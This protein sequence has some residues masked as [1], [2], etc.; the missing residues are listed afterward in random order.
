MSNEVE[1][2]PARA[3][4]EIGPSALVP[5]VE[6]HPPWARHEFTPDEIEIIKATVA[7]D[8]SDIELRLFLVVARAR[9]LD[10]FARQIYA[11]QRWDAALGRKAMTIQTSIDGLRL[12]A[13]RTGEYVGQVGPEWCG[14]DGVWRDAWLAEDT[15]PAAARVGVLR[16]GWEA[17]LWGVA[18]WESYV[19]RRQD[20]S[21]SAMWSRMSDVM[22]AKAAEAL[23]LRRTFPQDLSG[24]YT[25]DEMAQAENSAVEPRPR[26]PAPSRSRTSTAREEQSAP[27]TEGA[28]PLDPG[29]LGDLHFDDR[30]EVARVA[31][32]LLGLNSRDVE[33][34]LEVPLARWEGTPTEA[35]Q[36]IR[37]A[38]GFDAAPKGEPAGGPQVDPDLDDPD[39][40]R[41][42]PPLPVD[43]TE[44]RAAM[45]G[46]R[47]P[48]EGTDDRPPA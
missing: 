22:L 42:E 26:D 34:I 15:P 28:R 41:G 36:R 39:G 40:D 25:P 6:A 8:A 13:D 18:T 1:S 47:D 29:D 30:G 33:E 37:V 11:I 9:G 27:P 16:R 46:S 48:S 7:R 3:D 38:R 14:P 5:S 21:A 19:Q 20:G 24:L 23:A 43:I 2:R 12:I 4:E 31:R 45:A 17:P 32:E 10:P 35:W 44:G